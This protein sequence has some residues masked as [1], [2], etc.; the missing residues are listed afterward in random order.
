VNAPLSPHR[1]ALVAALGGFAQACSLA[2]PWDGQPLWWLQLLGQAAL[3]WLLLDSG[4]GTDQVSLRQV[5][6]RSW[7]LATV[8]LTATFGWLYTSMH[9]Y[10]G[11]AAPMAV[12]AVVA[13]A[14]YLALYWAGS[15]LVFAHV[16]SRFR[17]VH[18]TFTAITF[19]ALSLFAELARTVWFTGFPWGGAAYAHVD[20][21]LAAYAPWVGAHGMGFI[22]AVVA[23]CCALLARRGGDAPTASRRLSKSCLIALLL[24]VVAVPQALNAINAQRQADPAHSSGTL[25][26]ALLQ[27]NIAQEDKFEQKTG[28]AQALHWYGEALRRAPPGLIVAPETALPLLP[29]DMPDGYWAGVQAFIDQSAGDQPGPRAALIGTPLGDMLAGYTN[30]VY[31]LTSGVAQ[32]YR[33]DKHHLVPFGEFIPP[34]FRWFTNL[35]RIPLGDFNRGSLGQPSFNWQGQRIAPNIC[36]ED[37]FGEE[38]ATRFADPA[39]GPP[40]SPTLFVNLSNLAWFGDGQ[41]IDQHLQISRLRTLEFDRPMV[42]ATNTGATVVINHK[43]QV[44]AALPRSTRG[45]LSAT[46]EGRTNTTP[47]AHLTAQWGLW[48]WWGLCGSVWGLAWVW[49]LTLGRRRR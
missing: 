9:D 42:R 38:L 5:A 19:G 15:A 33:Y 43:G 46:A 29:Q 31:G 13:L 21:P 11:L 28:V 37:L 18:W 27:G 34:L 47:Y 3:A 7:T 39:S 6:L 26:L 4:F 2:T 8:W 25:A 10:G 22:A 44:T 35:M 48:P 45:I 1:T 20:G 36:Y 12:L 24:T 49:A 32:P 14:G 40:T 41:A 17:Q 16:L 23:M 30:S